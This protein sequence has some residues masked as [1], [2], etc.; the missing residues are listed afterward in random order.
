MSSNE[1]LLLID[2]IPTGLDAIK[3]ISVQDV[4]RIEI[5]KGSSTAMYGSRGANGVIAVFTKR[6]MYMKKG[7]ISFSVLGYH[8]TEQF[9]SPSENIIDARIEGAQLPLTVFWKPDITLNKGESLSITFA[10]STHREGFR[11]IFE[12]ISTQGNAGYSYAYFK[13]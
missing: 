6:G 3:S 4:D 2:G 1:P 9:Y 11:V 8:V 13:N 7:E 5:L 12:G 10:S